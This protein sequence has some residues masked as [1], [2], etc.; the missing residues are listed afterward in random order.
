MDGFLLHLKERKEE[1]ML[2]VYSTDVE[3][4]VDAAVPFNNV[5]IKKGCTAVESAPSTIQ[6]NKKG[7]YMVSMNASSAAAATLQLSKDGV[8]QPQAQSTGTNPSFLTLVQ[9]PY[10]NTE[11]CAVSPTVLQVINSGAAVATFTDVNVVVTKVC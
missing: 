10:D 1:N 5:Y 4:A 3:V 8:L 6:L 7:V 2:Q 9:V 11:C